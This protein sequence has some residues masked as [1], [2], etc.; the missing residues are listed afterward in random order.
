MADP[1]SAC[2]FAF[3]IKQLNTPTDSAS[4]TSAQPYRLCPNLLIKELAAVETKHYG[5][6][7][8]MRAGLSTI[9]KDSR[10]LGEVQNKTH[11]F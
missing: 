6:V 7:S 4:Q 1:Y 5:S 10:T 11:A 3:L 8:H 2:P 9:E